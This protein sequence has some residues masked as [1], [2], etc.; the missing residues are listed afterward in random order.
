M[1]GTLLHENA[2]S[3]PMRSRAPPAMTV[4][5]SRDDPVPQRNYKVI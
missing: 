3:N 4:A 5:F 1:S 2:D